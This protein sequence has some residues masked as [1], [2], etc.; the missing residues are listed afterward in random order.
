[1][2]KK[3]VKNKYTKVD[4][5]ITFDNTIS[6]LAK[7]IF[8]Y[9]YSKPETWDFSCKRAAKDFKEN[10]NTLER[11]IQELIDKKYLFREKLGSGRINY[12]IG[13]NMLI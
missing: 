1:M 12:Y 7:S 8:V 5:D 3:L 2:S 11:A 13:V 4:N 9:M 6:G 10:R